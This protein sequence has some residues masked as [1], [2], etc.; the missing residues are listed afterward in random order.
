MTSTYI[1]TLFAASAHLLPLGVVKLPAILNYIFP[2]V[3]LAVKLEKGISCE[4]VELLNF[5][6]VFKT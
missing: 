5:T 3:V 1:S 4:V 2:F 6:S